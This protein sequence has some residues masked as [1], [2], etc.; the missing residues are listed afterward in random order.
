MPKI[1]GEL[2]INVRS[3]QLLPSRSLQ[4]KTPQARFKCM[5]YGC[6]RIYRV[7]RVAVAA[8]VLNLF[9][10]RSVRHMDLTAGGCKHASSGCSYRE[11][12]SDKQ[13]AACYMKAGTSGGP[14]L[15]SHT[16]VTSAPP[17]STPAMYPGHCLPI[18]KPWACKASAAG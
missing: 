10:A 12:V 8:I 9:A 11:C 5:H 4:S 3:L 15:L 14:G 1:H 2:Y 7:Q 13:T 6:L 18:Y 17:T 16:L